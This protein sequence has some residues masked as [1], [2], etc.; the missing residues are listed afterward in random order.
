MVTLTGA[1]TVVV[2]AAQAATGNY[3]SGTQNASFTVNKATPTVQ[4][5]SS[6][7]VA[8]YGTA[9]VFNATLP[10]DAT[11]T[12]TFKRGATTMGTA[13][14]NGGT[15]TFSIST[16]PVNSYSITASYAGDSN[17]AAATSTNLTQVVSRAA[18]TVVE[19]SSLNPSIYGDQVTFT[20]V[21]S[22][23]GVTPGGTVSLS[24]GAVTLTTV[25]LDGGGHATYSIS[26]L[27][28]GTH[29]V[30]ATYNGDANYF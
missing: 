25:T 28:V 27:V 13:Q 6:A 21:V 19:T 24:D 10:V 8:P 30:L 22:G 5:A 23:A 7:S 9:I 2:Q 3:T 11:G 17:Y 14:A 16:L 12:V 18:A 4:L 26:A 1:G 20:V 15:A 29:T